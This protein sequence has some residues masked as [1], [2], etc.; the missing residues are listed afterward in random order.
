MQRLRFRVQ[1]SATEPYDLVAEGFGPEFRI[2][3]SCPGGRR[4]GR[5][6]KHVAALLVGDI[7][8]LV[9]PSDDVGVLREMAAG[10]RYVAA[11]FA[12][13]PATRPGKVGDPDFVETGDFASDVAAAGLEAERRG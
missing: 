4:G 11:A 13:D 10:T 12:H 5:F 6:C 1:G 9:D 8:R 2:F 7:T 3:C